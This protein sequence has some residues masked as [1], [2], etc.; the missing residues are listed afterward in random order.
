MLFCCGAKIKFIFVMDTF[1]ELFSS[2]CQSLLRNRF[3]LFLLKMLK[4]TGVLFVFNDLLNLQDSKNLFGL[5]FNIKRPNFNLKMRVGL[6][7]GFLIESRCIHA[8]FENWKSTPS[9]KSL[10]DLFFLAASLPVPITLIANYNQLIS[11]NQVSRFQCKNEFHQKTDCCVCV[12]RI[13]L[14][15][16]QCS[17]SLSSPSRFSRD[18]AGISEN[19]EQK[20]ILQT[21]E[22]LIQFTVV[23][24]QFR[25]LKY[26]TV[27]KIR[28]Y[29]RNIPF[30]SKRQQAKCREQC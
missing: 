21:T 8:N 20:I 22:Q 1:S 14:C 12:K 25:S 13:T 19:S 18:F 2:Y 6:S 4:L 11:R 30:L 17:S 26:V 24:I 15:N 27:I 3:L 5:V 16:C 7:N 9:E 10:W 23:E 29:L 28:K